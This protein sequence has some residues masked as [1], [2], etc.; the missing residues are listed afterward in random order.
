MTWRILEHLCFPFSGQINAVSRI[1]AVDASCFDAVWCQ[2]V[3]TEWTKHGKEQNQTI[4][5]DVLLPCLVT[6]MAILMEE[7][8]GTLSAKP[9]MID[10]P[11]G[12]ATKNQESNGI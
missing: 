5:A 6:N 7:L 4:F 10:V 11:T 2:M 1:W 12:K 9:A 8:E 3:V